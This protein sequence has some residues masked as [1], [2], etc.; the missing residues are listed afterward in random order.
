MGVILAVAII[1]HG[2]D[3]SSWPKCYSA[4]GLYDQLQVMPRS[5][6]KSCDSEPQLDFFKL[7]AL[8]RALQM[9]IGLL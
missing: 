1:S 6:V 9:P 3:L 4:H 2:Q 7:T 8:S 5:R